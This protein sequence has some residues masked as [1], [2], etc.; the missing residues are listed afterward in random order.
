MV[1]NLESPV[2]AQRARWNATA[3][4]AVGLQWAAILLLSGIAW[5]WVGNPGARSLLLGGFAVALPNGVLALWLTLRLYRSG[6]VGVAGML[7]GE[8]LKLVLTVALLVMGVTALKRE[9]VWLALI[10]GMIAA[11]K[12]QWLAV[13]FTRNS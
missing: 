7:A 2:T 6:P 3:S 4:K 11:L 10:V 12:A 9:I 1:A 8:L 13:W 5:I